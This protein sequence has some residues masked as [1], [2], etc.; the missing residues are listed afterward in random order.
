MTVQLGWTRQEQAREVAALLEPGSL[1]NVGVG[2][3][4][5]VPGE[6]DPGKHVLFHCENGLIGYRAL[7]DGEVPDPDIIDARCESIALEPGASVVSHDVSFAIARGGRLDVTVLGGFQVAGNGDLA[8]WSAG[9]GRV[10]GIGGAMDLAVGADRVIVMMRHNDRDG[11]PK[12]VDQCALPLTARGCVNVVV[13]ELAVIKVTPDG[14]LVDKLAPGV[15]RR[16]IQE[17][18]SVPLRFADPSFEVQE[19]HDQVN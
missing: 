5:L 15:G 10:A 4:V 9:A 2:M 3:P 16:Y 19:D 7:V 12:I 14:L 13:T 6:V 17:R 1:V 18:T 8:N 11:N